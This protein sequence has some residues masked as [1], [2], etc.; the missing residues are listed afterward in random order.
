MNRTLTLLLLLAP[1]AFADGAGGGAAPPPGGTERDSD[2]VESLDFPD[3]IRAAF[4]PDAPGL[5]LTYE[6]SLRLLGVTLFRLGEMRIEAMTGSMADDADAAP[7]CLLDCRMSPPTAA[8]PR[9]VLRDRFVLLANAGGSKTLVFTQLADKSYR[10]LGGRP[11]RYLRFDVNDYRGAEPYT[12]RTNLITGTSA[13]RIGERPGRERPGESVMAL[14]NL[15]A[16]VHAGSK[17]D[18]DEQSSPRF[19]AHVDGESRPFVVRTSRGDPP[20]EFPRARLDALRADVRAAPEAKTHQ[21]RLSAWVLPFP[22]LAREA[23]LAVRADLVRRPPVP[24]VPL[25]ADVELAVGTVRA[26][27]KGVASMEAHAEAPQTPGNSRNGG[28]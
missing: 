26:V 1:A 23:G 5:V 9:A 15:L 17:A 18:V 2:R 21:G 22:D 24:I 16:S 8:D 14:L 28:S 11:K 25:A 13:A 10:I 12:F 3:R 7:A 20:G 6:F 19:F 4:R 27:L